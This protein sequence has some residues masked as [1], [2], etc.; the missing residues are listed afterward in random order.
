M[1][2]QICLCLKAVVHFSL[3][4]DSDLKNTKVVYWY[5]NLFFVLLGKLASKAAV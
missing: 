3:K 2:L 4:L 5:Y 1:Q